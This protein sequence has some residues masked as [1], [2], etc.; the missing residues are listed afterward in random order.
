MKPVVALALVVCGTLLILAPYVSNTIGT[1]EIANSMV[2]LQKEVN[3]HGDM[4]D[5]YALGCYA[6]G[7]GMIVT[8]IIASFSRQTTV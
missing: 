6:G 5:W 1:A 7:I 4:P 2:Q 8:A 3:I